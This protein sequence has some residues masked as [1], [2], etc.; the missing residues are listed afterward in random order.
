MSFS[1]HPPL[2]SFIY[3]CVCPNNLFPLASHSGKE[4]YKQFLS[5]P[6][7]NLAPSQGGD[8]DMATDPDIEVVQ[9]IKLPHLECLCL[10][11]GDHTRNTEDVRP[12]S[13]FKLT[14]SHIFVRVV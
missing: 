12:V 11:L 1:V 4:L 9:D 14:R 13:N 7:S 10:H 6:G 8:L 2:A 3:D 5:I